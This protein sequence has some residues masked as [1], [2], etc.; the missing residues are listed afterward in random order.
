MGSLCL[1]WSPFLKKPC[2]LN[3]MVVLVY[4]Y[5]YLLWLWSNLL[6]TRQK[7][8][9]AVGV[10]LE[11]AHKHILPNGTG[12]LAA[13][14][15]SIV[16]ELFLAYWYLQTCCMLCPQSSSSTLIDAS[17]SKI[18]FD[19]MLLSL[20]AR[21]SCRCPLLQIWSHPSYCS[22]ELFAQLKPRLS[23]SNKNLIIQAVSTS[24]NLAA[25]MGPP[26][27]KSSKVTQSYW[28]TLT[29]LA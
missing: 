5:Q 8:I 22:G 1:L 13:F 26:A 19:F 24:G 12:S 14:Q 27:D 20:R 21:K 28:P 29:Q 11:E 17:A 25:A 18:T 4:K 9:E 23:D 16:V 7:S 10:L 6:Q 3:P 2:S 15:S